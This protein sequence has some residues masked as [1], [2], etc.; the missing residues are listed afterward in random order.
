MALAR[1][2]VTEPAVVL[3]DEPLANLDRHL[4]QEME[5]TFRE[6]HARSGATM[7]YVTHDQAEAMALATDVAVM[8]EG[9]LLQLATPEEIYARP[10]GALVGGLIGQGSILQVPLLTG[11]QRLFDWHALR[12][13]LTD[14]RPG[15]SSD[16]LVRP[17]DVEIVEGGMSATVASVLF[18]GERYALKLALADGQL[19]RAFSRQPVKVGDVLGIVIRSG[20]RL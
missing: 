17:Q 3:L 19:L 10:E 14:R 12:H 20:W 9:R 2:L 16:M 7:I 18:E 5:E 13:L 6:F 1:C 11:E 8:S 4:R 15:H